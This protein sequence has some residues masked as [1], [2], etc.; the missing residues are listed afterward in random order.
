M[1]GDGDG[2]SE[3][4]G[5]ALVELGMPDAAPTVL[6]AAVRAHP[7]PQIVSGAMQL[8]LLALLRA[9]H[10]VLLS[11]DVQGVASIQ[12][13]AAADPELGRSLVTVFVSPTSLSE[14]EKRLKGRAADA[15]EVIARRLASAQSEAERWNTFDYLLVS[16]TREEDL[17]RMQ[18]I[19]EVE[20]MKSARQEFRLAH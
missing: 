12:A 3:T 11:V 20:K 16:G 18:A 6:V 10:D 17:Q 2:P 15:P 19:L 14:L 7:E 9:G 1:L 5:E 13:A 8:T 4:T